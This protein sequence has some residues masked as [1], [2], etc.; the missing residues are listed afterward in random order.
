MSEPLWTLG[1][2]AEATE[3]R[4][5]GAARETPV[6][7]VSIDTRT[8]APGEVYFAIEG[9][10]KDGH[11][12][13]D[14]AHAA[15]AV[16]VVVARGE[17]S[18]CV[19]VDDTLAAMRRLGVRARERLGREAPVVAVTG[20]VGKTGTKELLRLAFG[21]ATT[22]ASAA[23]YN[24]HWGVPLSLARM[25]RASE[26]AVFEIGMNHAGEIEPL[27]K[28]VRPTIAIITTVAAVHLEFF[29]SVAG[30]A[31]A[32]A[33]IFVGLVEGGVAVIPADN[34]H[35]DRLAA[36][37]RQHGAQLVL[38]G[39]DPSADV[40]IEGFDDETGAVSARVFGEK[41]SYGVGEGGRHI[42]HNSLAVLAALHA[43][44]RDVA[45]GAARMGAWLAPKGRGRKVALEVEGG[46]VLLLDDAYNANPSSMAA[47]IAMLERAKAQRKVAILGDMLELGP[48]SPELHRGLAEHLVAAEVRIVHTVGA[49]TQHLRNAL[50]ADRRGLHAP[51][52]ATL[53]DEMP[54]L[55]PGDAVLVKGSLGSGLGPIVDALKKRYARDGGDA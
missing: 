30:I 22:H 42:A 13:V 3:G 32:K 46:E 21:E 18:P 23:S 33:E 43:A 17:P 14:A 10:A 20:S 40:V 15:G 45:E 34:E 7:G 24:N 44:G 11:E 27:T 4:L 48:T 5:V 54:D 39:A 50:P 41:V 8:L 52:A 6:T 51:D 49:M 12:F 26:A 55:E 37:T 9:V 1:A 28:L 16:A 47:A 36:A 35:A 31:D 25:P 29:D 19:V 2:L 53:L 38:F